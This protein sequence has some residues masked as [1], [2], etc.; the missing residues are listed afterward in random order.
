MLTA[1]LPLVLEGGLLN[2]NPGLI[3]WTVIT[4][5]LLMIFL[6]KFAWKPILGALSEREETI[7][8]S[9][10]RAETARAEA[11]KMLA[12][13]RAERAKAQVDA[14]K[15][16]QE[17]KGIGEKLRT[18]IVEKANA[19]GR[20]LIEDAKKDIQV[21]TERARAALRAEVADLAVKGA[22]MIIKQNLN[23]DA[24]KSLIEG[25]ISKMPTLT[26]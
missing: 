24:Q 2:V 4:F 3:F 13:V 19:E 16:I 10:D 11:E 6:A 9:L 17:A 8:K 21:E 25:V 1:S 5:S 12:D 20:K 18:D 26:N 15:L 7:Q 14:D 22:E 23:A